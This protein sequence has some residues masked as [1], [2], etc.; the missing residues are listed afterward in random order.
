MEIKGAEN[1]MNTSSFFSREQWLG[2]LEGYT[3]DDILEVC[4]I[5]S[6]EVG[7]GNILWKGMLVLFIE[8]DKEL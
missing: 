1:E 2:H 3:S 6:G 7:Y 8:M 4:K 5:S